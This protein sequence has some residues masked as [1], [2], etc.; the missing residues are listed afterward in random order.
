MADKARHAFGALENID[1]ALAAGVIDSYDIIFAKD[2]KGKPYV[3]WI[4]KDGNKVIVEDEKA[5]VVV[6]GDS[7]PETGEVG[8]VYIFV[9]H[10]ASRSNVV[11]FVNIVQHTVFTNLCKPTDVTALE[12]Q[13]SE[14]ETEVEQ[15]VDA[16]TVRIMIEEHSDSLIEVVEF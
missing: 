16:E 13:V 7:L 11:Y 2:S 10:K 6:D 5:V 3:G 9:I 1:S 8:K 15:K 12:S 4:D 14:L